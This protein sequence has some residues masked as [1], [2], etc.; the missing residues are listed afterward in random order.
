VTSEP[1]GDDFPVRSLPGPVEVDDSVPSSGRRRRAIRNSAA[2]T[3]SR[4]V[5]I[6]TSFALT[7]LI[8]HVTGPTAFGLWVLIGSV[9][10]YGSLLDL[11]IGGALTKYVAQYRAL[12]QPAMARSAIRTAVRLYLVMGSIVAAIGVLLSPAI[13][14]LLAIPPEQASAAVAT[15]A[16]MAI[17][18]GIAIPC[19][20]ASAVLRGLQRHDLVASIS[21][22]GSLASVVTTV[23]ALALGWGIV[24]IVGLGLPIP[25]VT[26]GLALVAIRRM[27]P[28]L[29]D[30][31]LDE[32][33]GWRRRV[34]GFSWPLL[35][36]DLAGRLQSKS[37]EI[38]VG[39][40]LSLGAVAPYSLGRKLASI[41]R[42]IAEQFAM[43][44]LPWASDLDARRDEVRLQAL[45]LGGV[46]ISLAIA[47]PLTGCLIL[48]AV[49]ILELWI[50]PGYADGGPILVTLVVAALIDLSL[51]P[52]G[53]VLQGIARHHWVGPIS[54]AS[55]L[56]NLGLSLALAGPFGIFGV[57]IG[58]LIPTIIE[59]AAVL[60]PFTLRT[61][62]IPIA[63]FL[64]E[65][66]GP[67]LFPALPMLLV[68][69]VLERV[70]PP[71]SIPAVIGL[72]V[73]AHGVYGL[74]YL[75]FPVTAPERA[76]LRDIGSAIA[77]VTYARRGQGR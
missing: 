20:A 75:Q 58:T 68:V 18:L 12:G 26:Q 15:T 71:S 37:D 22:V 17:G 66:V 24:G 48:L 77:G 72:I 4:V 19:T 9:V 59:T 53:F 61:L 34:L 10:A 23:A 54:L 55:G 35:A 3:L 74:L 76:S 60:T 63:R 8:L 51:W 52:A 7:P 33:P 73:V 45:Y 21:I 43:L 1:A 50:G 41:P 49:P 57:A 16:L 67:A 65:A 42:L 46:R 14:T 36:L 5:S 40:A 29:L 2:N 32:T 64:R 31:P 47:V 11:G 13:P 44:L 62:R 56:A 70:V 25:I 30:G 28:K 69:S 39:V 27:A 38:V 6:A